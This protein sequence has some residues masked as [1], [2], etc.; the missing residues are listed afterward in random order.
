MKK[1]LDFERM[2]HMW[3]PHDV[4]GER[5]EQQVVIAVIVMAP[6]MP[7]VH[8]DAASKFLRDMKAHARKQRRK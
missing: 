5:Q 7:V 8:H 3:F 2:Q 6:E 1:P 4:D